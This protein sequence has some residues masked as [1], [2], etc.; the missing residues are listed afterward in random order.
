MCNYNHEEIQWE[1]ISEFD[2]VRDR[3]LSQGSG[4]V[5]DWCYKNQKL[6]PILSSCQQKVSGTSIFM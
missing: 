2:S 3:N 6:T 5:C 1:T 4:V